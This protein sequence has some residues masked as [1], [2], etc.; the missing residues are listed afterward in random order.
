MGIKFIIFFYIAFLVLDIPYFTLYTFIILFVVV[1]CFSYAVIIQP[2]CEI[3]VN[4]F[5]QYV[6]V[7]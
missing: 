3:Y 1:H 4:N 7:K 6:I 5:E 2:Q